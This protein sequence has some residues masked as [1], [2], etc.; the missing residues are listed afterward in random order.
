MFNSDFAQFLQPLFLIKIVVLLLIALYLF[1]TFVVFN[2]VRVMGR[3][4]KETSTSA[5]VF[6]LALFNLLLAFSLF[7]LALVIL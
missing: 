1:F 5:I 3:I 2:Q 7:L 6:L 4:V